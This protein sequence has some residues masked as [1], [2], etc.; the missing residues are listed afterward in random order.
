VN[1]LR[2]VKVKL[3]VVIF[4]AIIALSL[5]T[6]V[7]LARMNADIH[8]YDT[9]I[10]IDEQASQLALQA[11]VEFKRQV[12]EWKNI[13]IRGADAEDMETYWTRFNQRHNSV[14]KTIEEL[15][16]LLPQGS[17]LYLIAK[18]FLVDHLAMKNAYTEGRL[19]FI[20]S[21]FNVLQGDQSV[22][23]IDRAPST[24]LDTIVDL[25]TAQVHQ[26]LD[27]LDKSVQQNLRLS[28]S[29]FILVVLIVGVISF[30]VINRVIVNPLSKVARNLALLGQGELATACDYVNEDEIGDIAETA[31]I[32][33]GFLTRNVETMKATSAALTGSS[34]NLSSMSQEL[35]AQS[36]QQFTA[37]EQVATAIQEMSHSAEE[38]ANNSAL[39]LDTTKATA[40]KS[41]AGTLTA[42]AAKNKSIQLVADL[43]A[44]AAVMKELAENATN[45]SSVLD[46]IRGIA[47]QTNLLAL[48]AAIE[49]A[50]AGDQGRGFAVVA[51]EVRTL[52]QRTQD[53]TTEIE[54]ILDSVKKGADNAVVAMDKGQLSS[55]E[56]EQDITN[57]SNTLQ[58]I[59]IMVEDINEKNIQIATASKEQTEVASGIS[60]LMHDIQ[61]LAE[62]TNHKVEQT[63]QISHELNAL[64]REFDQQIAQFKL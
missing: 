46:V 40:E 34:Q 21:G 52:A 8:S 25:L 11:N 12:Q 22:S 55:T 10:H 13:L 60:S 32:L 58:E 37:T 14:Q 9:L 2:S 38:V 59:A 36:T 41:S 64:I 26:K 4:S 17:E 48:N 39:T 16:T 43:N 28:V 6:F 20:D 62:A 56:T 31:R 49:A 51:D 24:A 1:Y 15:I 3:L 33:H 7:A 29:G 27:V 19:K 57:A 23:G 47:E 18:Q 44:G 35:S 45:V 42:D 63:E 5:V 53:S 61:N 54:R 30:I 50:R